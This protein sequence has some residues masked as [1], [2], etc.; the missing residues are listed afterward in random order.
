MFSTY[1]ARTLPKVPN[2][3]K[4]FGRFPVK[5]VVVPR[6]KQQRSKLETSHRK[7]MCPFWGAIFDIVM[8]KHPLEGGGAAVRSGAIRRCHA[9]IGALS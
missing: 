4:R 8:A 1:H 2:G 9:R 5:E 3:T 7:F 6:Q